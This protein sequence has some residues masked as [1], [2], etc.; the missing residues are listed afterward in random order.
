MKDRVSTSPSSSVATP[1]D[2]A[3]RHHCL[4][5]T[6]RGGHVSAIAAQWRKETGQK[7]CHY[8][9]MKWPLWRRVKGSTQYM[10]KKLRT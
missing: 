6:G 7:R 3:I 4:L 5:R 8:L 9:S 1:A 10:N 2:L